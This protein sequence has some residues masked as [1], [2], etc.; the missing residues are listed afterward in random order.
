M[1]TEFTPLM[2]LLGGAL[3]GAAAV[4]LMATHGRI[5]GVSGIV[6]KLL[7]P[8]IDRS[9]ALVSVAVIAGLILATPL[10]KLLT[11]ALPAQTISASLPVLAVAGL[12]VGVGAGTGNGCTSGHGVCGISRLSARSIVATITFLTTGVATVTLVRYLSGA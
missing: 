5:A 3:I 12:L 4:L 10:Y 6:S 2:S 11:G 9:G 1:S 8:G 7:P